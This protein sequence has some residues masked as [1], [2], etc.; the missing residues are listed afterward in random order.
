MRGDLAFR[1]PETGS[2]IYD[3]GLKLL[4]YVKKTK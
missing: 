1:N 3:Y 2:V 4:M